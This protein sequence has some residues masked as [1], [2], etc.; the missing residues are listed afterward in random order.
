MPTEIERK[1]L[2][3]AALWQAL[4]KPP[5]SY[6][7]QGYI[8]NKHPKSL[9]V[10]I[11]GDQA[12]LNLKQMTD[13]LHRHEFEYPI[14]LEDAHAMLNDMAENDIVKTR[15]KKPAGP[16]T[17]EVDVFAGAN[18]GLVVAEI[19]LPHAAE[20][21]DKPAWI[22]EEVTHDMRYLNTALAEKPF[23]TWGEAK[24]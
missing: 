15:Y 7:R 19:E 2:V 20:V 23:T 1:F 5:G 4:P 17:W 22:G 21:F 18:A 8:L 16:F 14:P 6:I 11:Q 24:G 9:R 3:D 12:T 10:R 13:A